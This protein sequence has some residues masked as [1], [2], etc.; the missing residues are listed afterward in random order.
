MKIKM[1]PKN[2]FRENEE[3]VCCGDEIGGCSKCSCED[4]QKEINSE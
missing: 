4:L 3:C 1:K 2:K